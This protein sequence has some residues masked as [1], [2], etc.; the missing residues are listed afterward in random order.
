MQELVDVQFKLVFL[1]IELAHESAAKSIDIFFSFTVLNFERW[2][3]TFRVFTC[4]KNGL[5]IIMNKFARK[6][7]FQIVFA[8]KLRSLNKAFSLR[9]FSFE[10]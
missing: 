7:G 1:T 3:A 5:K 6:F 8:V 9:Q 10:E 2:L 4:I